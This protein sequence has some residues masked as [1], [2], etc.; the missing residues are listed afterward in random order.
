MSKTTT[1]ETGLRIIEL[2]AENLK[3]LVAVTIT[4]KGDLVQITG[5]N[6]QGKTSVLDS[7]WWA[8][9]GAKNI[10]GQPIR[11]GQER[12]FVSVKLGAE[13][14]KLVVTREFTAG[15]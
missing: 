1:D 11:K 8:L 5:R 3:R 15:G 13:T 10:Q 4:P 2:R 6:G 14:V 9:G 7:I 12:A